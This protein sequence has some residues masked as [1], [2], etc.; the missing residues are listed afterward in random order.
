MG[1]WGEF[2]VLLDISERSQGELQIRIFTVNSVN[3]FATHLANTITK[4]K[5]VSTP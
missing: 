2:N 1:E 3:I 4:L 5:S